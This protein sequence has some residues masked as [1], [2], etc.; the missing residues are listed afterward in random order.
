MYVYTCFYT[1]LYRVMPNLST[2]N[3]T[4]VTPSLVRLLEK[5]SS[6]D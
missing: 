2:E 3:V 1:L 5:A 6:D 4:Q